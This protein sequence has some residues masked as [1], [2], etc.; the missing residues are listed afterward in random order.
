MKSSV[1]TRRSSRELAINVSLKA[2]SN[3]EP[4]IHIELLKSSES[5]FSA[6]RYCVANADSLV[7]FRI[8]II[9]M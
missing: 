6:M 8:I 9:F 3:S 2:K 4:C 5:I 7:F 1:G